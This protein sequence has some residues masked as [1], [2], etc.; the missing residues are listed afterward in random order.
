[1][2]RVEVGF[3]SR[4]TSM[5]ME[6]S[7]VAWEGQGQDFAHIGLQCRRGSMCAAL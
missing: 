1:M 2:G 4:R 5:E 7:Y 6:M 3:H